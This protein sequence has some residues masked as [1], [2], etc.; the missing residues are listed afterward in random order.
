MD[1]DR[2]L[3]EVWS[4]CLDNLQTGSS[5]RR[6]IAWRRYPQQAARLEELLQ[7]SQQVKA[8]PLPDA[9]GADVGRGRATAA[10]GGASPSGG[11]ARASAWSQSP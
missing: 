11:T 7:L 4:D 5:E 6:R 8:M 9:H 10:A 2:V 1:D 3:A